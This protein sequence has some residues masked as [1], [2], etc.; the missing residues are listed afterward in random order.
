MSAFTETLSN[1]E[2][3]VTRYSNAVD[4]KDVE[5]FL[6]LF[7]E[8]GTFALANFPTAVGPEQIRQATAGFFSSV[9]G[10]K[11]TADAIHSLGE[12]KSSIIHFSC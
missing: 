9:S 12:R 10:M 8:D 5:T 7:A 1:H 11:H 2:E 6:S 3:F 4:T